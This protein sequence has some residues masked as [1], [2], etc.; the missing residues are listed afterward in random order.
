MS[1]GARAGERRASS[2]STEVR[3]PPLVRS[4]TSSS[5]QY[6]RSRTRPKW[7]EEYGALARGEDPA[8]V[9]TAAALAPRRHA[10]PKRGGVANA[11]LSQ[12]ERK[13]QRASGSASTS[14]VRASASSRRSPTPTPT[15]PP[16]AAAR[17]R[18]SNASSPTRRRGRGRRGC[19]TRRRA[20]RRRR[21]RRRRVGGAGRRVHQVVAVLQTLEKRGPAAEA[22]ARGAAGGE[23]EARRSVKF[24]LYLEYY[25]SDPLRNT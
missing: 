8:A 5:F 13:A 25:P 18:R 24:K 12:A 20:L 1:A 11:E 16:R 23:G 3:K 17:A 22:S 7:C 4:S 19:S 9:A 10:A 14:A 2:R 6:A 15:A 21:R